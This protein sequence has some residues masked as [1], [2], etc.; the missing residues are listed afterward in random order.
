MNL[1]EQQFEFTRA[2]GELLSYIYYM[3]YQAT[4]GCARCQLVGHHKSYSKHYVGLAIDI[5]L[6]KDGVYL[7]ETSDHLIFGEHWE[8]LGGSWGGRFKNPDGNHYSWGE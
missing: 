3:G 2:V 7:K 8:R 4:L 6:F 5:N 1:N